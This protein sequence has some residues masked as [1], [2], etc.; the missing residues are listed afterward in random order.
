MSLLRL[1]VLLVAIWALL[2]PFAA[3]ATGTPAGTDIQSTAQVRYTVSGVALIAPSNTSSLIVAEILDVVVTIASSTVT[4]APSTSRQ[5]LVFTVT[6]TGNG[7]ET[8]NL[9]GLSAGVA[10][11]DFDPALAATAIYFDTDNSGDLS[12]ADTAYIAG[13]NDPALAADA[14]VRVLVIND[15]PAAATQGQRGRSQLTAIA[16]TG[17]GTPG[18]L[19]PGLGDGG[20][21][22]LAGTTGADGASFGEYLVEALQV[23]ATKSQTI[24]DPFG[25]TRPVPGARIHYQIV[26]AASGGNSASGATF[27]DLI[28]ANTS[29]VAG[30]LQLNSVPLSD[31][32]DSD[33]GEFAAAPAPQVRINL[34]DLTQAL[35]PQTVEFAVTI[36]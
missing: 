26:V 16:R 13:T 20:V 30:S 24:Q 27:S 4:V 15:I 36:N 18:T 25:G 19:F 6:N 33:A 17:S 35:G 14:S 10:G 7:T 32:A 29:Y 12:V 34:G 9:A 8:F 3:H 21:D 11:D 2:A 31:N 22:A 1:S 28:P 23:S 5:E